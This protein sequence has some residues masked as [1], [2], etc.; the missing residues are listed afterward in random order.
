MKRGLDLNLLPIATAL[1]E[2]RSVTVA[3]RKLGMSQPALSE[4]LGKLRKMVDDELFIKTGY[5]MVPTPRA[6]AL[7]AI[8]RETI[9]RLNQEVFAGKTFDPAASKATLNFALTEVQEL[10]FFPRI[11]RAI[12]ILAP[13]MR[14]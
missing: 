12:Q 4:L 9:T 7:V 14:C 1:Y 10:V 2:E 3:A 5:A 6:H 13:H 11:L 8:A